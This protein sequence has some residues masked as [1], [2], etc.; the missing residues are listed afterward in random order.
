MRIFSQ[1]LVL[2]TFFIKD[3]NFLQFVVADTVFLKY[4]KVDNESTFL[5]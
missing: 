5:T 3:A 2:F 1:V 4:G